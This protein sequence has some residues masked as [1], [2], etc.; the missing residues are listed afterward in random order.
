MCLIW[1]WISGCSEPTAP[2]TSEIPAPEGEPRTQQEGLPPPE[3]V[4][5]QRPPNTPTFDWEDECP[6]RAITIVHDAFDPTYGVGEDPVRFAEQELSRLIAAG[7]SMEPYRRGA[8]GERLV[9]QGV[10]LTGV[11]EMACMQR[12]Y[13]SQANRLQEYVQRATNQADGPRRRRLFT[14]VPVASTVHQCV[15]G[16]RNGRALAACN[17]AERSLRR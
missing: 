17:D 12:R 11:R 15:S 1:L 16:M 4:Q 2:A 10:D 8:A 13:Q 9:E 6:A 7:R 3:A 5:E 14:L